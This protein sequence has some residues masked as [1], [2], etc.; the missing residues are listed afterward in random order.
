MKLQLAKLIFLTVLSILKKVLDLLSFK[1]GK[2]SED[3]K[4]MREQIF[5]YFYRQTKN[6]FKQLETNKILK[7]CSCSANL[8]KGY[9]D[10]ENCGGSGYINFENEEK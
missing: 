2:E 8:R 5:D 6:L 10:C 9:Q 4:Y 7:R 3:Y 1:I